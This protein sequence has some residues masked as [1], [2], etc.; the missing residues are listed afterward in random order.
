MHSNSMCVNIKPTYSYT[1]T[2]CVV[3]ALCHHHL[4][5]ILDR[6][7]FYSKNMLNLMKEIM[8]LEMMTI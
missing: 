2:I 6:K 3:K 8:Y 5:F 1:Q 7:A 4:N